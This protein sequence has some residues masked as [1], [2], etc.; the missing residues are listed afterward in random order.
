MDKFSSRKQRQ[1][2]KLTDKH[3]YPNMIPK[4]KVKYAT[5]VFSNSVSNFLG[6]I[7]QS[8]GKLI[9]LLCLLTLLLSLNTKMQTMNQQNYI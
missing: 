6:V 5:Q 2:P 7:L 1:M 9:F 3:I 8:G 4:M